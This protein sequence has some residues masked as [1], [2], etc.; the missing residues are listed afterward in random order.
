[1]TERTERAERYAILAHP[2]RIFSVFSVFSVFSAF[3]AL[4]AQTISATGRVLGADST[5]VR[6]VRVLLH[7]VGQETQGPID[8]TRSDGRGRFQFTFRPDTSAFYLLSAEH[9]GIEY[10]SPPVATNPERPD[11]GIRILVYDTSSTTPISLVARHLV[12]A[13]P[14][15]DGSR[16][17]LDL[18]ALRNDSRLTRTT[19]DTTR[20]TWSAPL[21]PGT[22]GLE[23]SESDFSREAVARRDDSVI[24]VAPF[25]PGEKQLT[26]QYLI[27]SGRSVV[28]LPFGRPGAAINVLAEER[29]VRVTGSGV[30]LA[31]SQVL[32]GR[33][34]RRWTG[35]AQ[36]GGVVRIVLPGARRTPTRLLAVLVGTLTL[37]LA[38]AGW[39]LLAKPRIPAPPRAG[40]L[41][42]AIAALDVRYAGREGETPVD[43][44]SSYLTERAR[45]RAQLEASLAAGGQSR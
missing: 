42:A 26:V 19:S 39:R 2:R 31:D 34:F 15:Q 6:G 28:E 18:M 11:T 32:Q 41:I 5:P 43:E 37:V 40:E 22:I 4:S 13:R 8:S 20:P 7:R 30:A 24:V 33:S 21:P 3:S 9:A 10:F 27:P 35:V 29:G 25:A 36:A 17:V 14:G 16:G 38:A 45:I 1:M 23:L 44:W 12:I